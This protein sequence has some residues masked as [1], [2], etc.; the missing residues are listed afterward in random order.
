M[1]ESE[2]QKDITLIAAASD[3]HALG[4]DNQLIWLFLT[5]VNCRIPGL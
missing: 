5:V 4:K 3:N 2:F 1:N